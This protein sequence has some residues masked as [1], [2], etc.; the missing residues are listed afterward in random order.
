MMAG[1]LQVFAGPI[2]DASGTVRVAEGKV[3]GDGDLW[4]MDW[5]I[6][7]VTMQK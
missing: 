6:P 1:K 3:I 7:G 2:S 4:K 5:F